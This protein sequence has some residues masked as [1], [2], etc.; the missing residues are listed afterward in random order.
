MTSQIFAQNASWSPW[1]RLCLQAGFNYVVS[2]TKTPASAITQAELNSQNN[3][4]TVTFDSSVVVDDKTD[5]NVGFVYYQADNY[6]NNSSVGLPLGT[7]AD[8]QTLTASLTRRITPN[9]RVNLKYA[10]THYNDWASGGNNN[11]NAQ[12]VYSSLQY[13]F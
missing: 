10:Y 7:G 1:S 9:L 12:M 8:E 13:R 2:E 6:N 5:L 3:Y 11:Y 4:W